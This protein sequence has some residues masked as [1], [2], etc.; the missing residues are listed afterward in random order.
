MLKD[1]VT[2]IGS[3][4]S[5]YGT[6]QIIKNDYGMYLVL[7]DASYPTN[8]TKL[9]YS[10][11]TSANTFSL[12]EYQYPRNFKKINNRIYFTMN[13]T[14]TNLMY[15]ENNGAY[16]YPFFAN[17]DTGGSV[18]N[19]EDL[20]VSGDTLYLTADYALNERRLYLVN[21]FIPSI[22]Y[23]VADI[24]PSA[25]SNPFP[26]MAKDR[27]FIPAGKGKMY[28]LA[29]NGTNGKELWYTDGN[30]SNTKMVRDFKPNAA[31]GSYSF[32]KMYGD[33]L[34]FIADTS[35]TAAE[36]YYTQ[37]GNTPVKMLSIDPSKGLSNFYPIAVSGGNL[38]F[39]AFDPIVGY[40]LFKTNGT[41]FTLIKDIYTVNYSMD[42][43]F[44][45]Q[46][47]VL[48]NKL[49]FTA[50]DGKVGNEIWSTNGKSNQTKIPFE[51]YRYP[52]EDGEGNGGRH[53]KTFTP[54]SVN[55][56]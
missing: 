56:R 21:N 52:T 29:N 9:Y 48:N 42:Y 34:F 22:A 43:T 28:F 51:I 46:S 32:M 19:A 35:A 1:I 26:A 38:Y 41:S 10:D 17:L 49:F 5:P 53:A 44:F 14:Y 55:E 6:N 33:K 50:V 37:N 24:V 20:T 11:G 47:V 54:P 18:L 30:W 27:K 2:G 4:A 23:T 13:D 31:D 40:E 8:A 39:S 45:R 7:Y 12:G 16:V 15:I 3:S 36:C 25:N